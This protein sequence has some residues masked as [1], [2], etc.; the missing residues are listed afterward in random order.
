MKKTG[1]MRTNGVIIAGIL[2]IMPLLLASQDRLSVSASSNP[3]AAGQVFRITYSVN[4]S[5]ADFRRPDFTPFR[6]AGGPYVSASTR[7]TNG[8]ASVSNS[9][10]FDLVAPSPG[11]YTIPPA[12]I[13]TSAGVIKSEPIQIEVVRGNASVPPGAPDQQSPVPDARERE[14]FMRAHLNK[15]E[16]FIGEPI[17]LTFKVYLRV[18]VRHNQVRKIPALNGFWTED[19]DYS[20]PA[21]ISTELVDGVPYKVAEIKKSLLFPQRAGELTIDPMEMLF[22][23]RRRGS[24]GNP[25]LDQFFGSFEEEEVIA[26]SP[27]VKVHVRPLPQPRPGSFT[28]G[29]GNFSLSSSIERDSLPANEATR[30]KI[31]ISGN[32][33]LRLIEQPDL[34]FPADIESYKPETTDKITL[35]NNGMNGSRTWEFLLIPRHPGEFEIPAYKFT[36][37]DPESGTYR[38]IQTQAYKLKVGKGTSDPNGSAERQVRQD[39]RKLNEDI[40]YIVESPG[41]Y[42]KAGDSFV[43]SPLY[44]GIMTLPVGVFLLFLLAV[45]K[46]E[47]SSKDVSGTKFR[48]AFKRF[49]QRMNAAEAHLEAGRKEKFIDEFFHAVYGYLSDKLR[50][51]VTSLSKELIDQALANR[52]V[53]PDTRR[54]LLKLLEDAEFARFAPAAKEHGHDMATRGRGILIAIDQKIT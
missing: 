4:A 24:T 41:E 47:E 54:Q 16:A 40:R 6:L 27:P 29:V 18:D 43:G 37:L 17:L 48:R 39:L 10:G 1:K 52:Q 31:T 23:I 20:G 42:L 9:Y 53:E 50:V 13:R 35:G 19:F 38:D 12:T 21:E 15:R 7:I 25:L 44:F 3:V 2:L 45:K 14:I 26:G 49:T 28:G 22:I 34:K 51:P 46:R 32:G 11:R 5:A 33:N 30:L 8:Q 36:F